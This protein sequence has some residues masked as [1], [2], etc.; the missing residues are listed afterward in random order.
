MQKFKTFKELYVYAM[1]SDNVSCKVF[2]P[3]IDAYHYLIRDDF[4]DNSRMYRELSSNFMDFYPD[5]MT[6]QEAIRFFTEFIKK[7]GKYVEV[8]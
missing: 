6:E 7:E 2:D 1:C 8:N 5:G 4:E 3:I